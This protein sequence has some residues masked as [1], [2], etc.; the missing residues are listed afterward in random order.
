MTFASIAAMYQGV[1]AQVDA[2]DSVTISLADFAINYVPIYLAKKEA[3]LDAIQNDVSQYLAASLDFGDENAP[4]VAAQWN[5]QKS[6]DSSLMD[7]GSSAIN[8]MIENAKSEAS[9]NETGMQ[10]AIAAQ[11]PINEYLKAL[12]NLIATGL[13]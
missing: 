6:L 4:A 11:E 12:V 1:E 7:T 9:A 13:R 3:G 8:G 10:N 5:E 2:N